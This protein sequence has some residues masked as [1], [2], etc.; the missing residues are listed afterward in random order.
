VCEI[1]FAFNATF[2]SLVVFQFEA[3][4]LLNTSQMTEMAENRFMPAKTV[5]EEEKCVASAIPKSTGNIKT[6]V[7][8]EFV[9]NT[10]IRVGKECNLGF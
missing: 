4:T 1:I 3:H 5:E 6:N 2:F 9:R 10:S 7:R 8:L